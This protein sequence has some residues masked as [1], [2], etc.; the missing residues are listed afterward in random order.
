VA[1]AIVSVLG[2]YVYPQSFI[3]PGVLFLTLLGLRRSSQAARGANLLIFVGVT[4]VGAL[5]FVWLVLRDPANFVSGYI[6]GKL[7]GENALQRLAGNSLNALLAFNLRGDENFRSN[8]AQLPHLDPLSGLLFLAGVV[9]WLLPTRRRWSPALLLPLLLLQL[10]SVLVLSLP[11]EVPSASRTLGVAPL[12]YILAASGLWWLLQAI[13]GLRRARRLVPA[14]AGLALGAILL[15]N[16]QRYFVSYIDGLPYQNTHIGSAIVSYMDLLP[17]ETQIYLVGC[18]WEGGMPEP[19][20][21][22]SVM[23]R[24]KSFRR[25]EPDR[26]SCDQLRFLNQPAVFVWSSREKLPAPQLADCAAWLP[27]QLYSSPRGLPMFYAAPLLV[28][29]P[30]PPGQA[31]APAPADA[32]LTFTQA[33]LGAEPIGVRHSPI[34]I[35]SIPDLFDG[36]RNSL[37]RGADANPLVIELRFTAP[38][39]LSA[40]A[41]DLGTMRTFKV[42][43]SITAADGAPREL[44]RSYQNLPSD[45]H[46]ELELGDDAGPAQV[47]RVTITDLDAPPADGWHIHVREL[48]LR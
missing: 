35:G 15:L 25:F 30:A 1:C 3:L 38:R 34:D 20:G 31:A 24:P 11:H 41:L 46:V 44:T 12:A 18:C 10:P 23:R 37:I 9:F 2:L 28:G 17:P 27:A 14:V 47:L 8:P 13:G 22:V 33:E 29:Q 42:A 45:P 6:G 48:A 26:L 16:A 7:A 19:E 43:L 40:V 21:M 4:L 5:P 32:Q 36:D 39:P